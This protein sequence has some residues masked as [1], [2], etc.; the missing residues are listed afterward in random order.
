MQ[1]QPFMMST[2]FM[3]FTIVYATLQCETI[4]DA[5]S[6]TLGSDAASTLR[7]PTPL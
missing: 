3:S 5:Y 1:S 2:F 7:I 6:S 4:S